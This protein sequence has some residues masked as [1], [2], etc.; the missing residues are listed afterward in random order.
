MSYSI[1]T[2]LYTGIGTDKVKSSLSIAALTDRYTSVLKDTSFSRYASYITQIV[3]SFKQAPNNTEYIADQ[4]DVYGEIAD[5]YDEIMLVLNNDKEISDM[6]LAMLGYYTEEEF[7]NLVY[8]VSTV[9]KTDENGNVVLDEKGNPVM[10]QDLR[11]TSPVLKPPNK[12]SL[13][14]GLYTFVINCLLL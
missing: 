12:F 13:M 3:P 11:Y 8:K 10:I 7:Y 9:K 5:E 4:Y 1:Y 2:N 14:E 6:L